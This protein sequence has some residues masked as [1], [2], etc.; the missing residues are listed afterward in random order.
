M[1]DV[2]GTSGAAPIWAALMKHLHRHEAS[3]APAPPPGVVHS[4]TEFGGQLE[5]A[6][7][8]WFIQGTEQAL[9][10]I[11]SIAYSARSQSAS[12]LKHPKNSHAAA[13]VP[14]RIT[15]PALGTILALDPDIPPAHQRL[16]FSAGG[17]G[18]RWRMDGKEFARGNQAQWLP[19]PGRHVVQ[20]LDASGKVA[21]E[22]RLEVRGAG[23]RKLEKSSDAATGRLK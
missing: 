5:A 6:R 17:Q 3:R 10:A 22:I 8:E 19:W 7:S 1:W 12:G 9:F 13:G 23:V 14:A 21:D 11:D 18:L 16:T 20:L 4:R 2:S 15:A